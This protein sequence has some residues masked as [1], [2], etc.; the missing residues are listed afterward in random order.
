[1]ICLAD[2][3][4]SMQIAEIHKKTIFNGFLVKLGVD[5][6]TLL[7]DFLIENEL[8]LVSIEDNKV[9]GFVSCSVSSSGL[10]KKFILKKPKAILL[11]L[12]KIILNPSF[13][14][15]I[16]ET[17]K[18]TSHS[19]NDFDAENIPQ[20]ELLSISVLPTTQQKGMG[21]L[22]INALEE[23]L[24]IKNKHKYKVIAGEKLKTA[25]SFYLKNGFYL[26]GQIKIHGED[27]SNVYIKDIALQN[28]K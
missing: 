24:L 2:K 16:L 13:I 17:A 1:M 27:I 3:N 6:L 8:V 25:N 12:K 4:H 9:V 20:T 26:N 14:K 22:L 19:M 23:N 7:Y 21:S 11:L 5:F 28:T 18:S 15:P 10:M